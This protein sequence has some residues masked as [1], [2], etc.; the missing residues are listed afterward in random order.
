M[1]FVAGTFKAAYCPS[2]SGCRAVV[3]F[4]ELYNGGHAIDVYDIAYTLNVETTSGKPVWLVGNSRSLKY[5]LLKYQVNV[6]AVSEKVH[7]VRLF[8]Y[9]RITYW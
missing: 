9:F 7:S 2:V 8:I 1:L 3:E 6:Q 4:E 5:A